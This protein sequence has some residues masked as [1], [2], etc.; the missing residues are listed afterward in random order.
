MAFSPNATGKLL[1]H[2]VI[3]EVATKY[4]VSVPQLSIRYDLQLGLLPLPRS[5]NPEHIKENTE[6]AFSIDETDMNKLG[7]IEEIQSL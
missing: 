6:L 3:S 7:M 5:I 2:P 4:G 1:G